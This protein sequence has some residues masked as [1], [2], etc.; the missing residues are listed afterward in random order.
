MNEIFGEENFV[1][2]IIWE[3]KFAPQNDARWFSENH[4][5]ILAI[6]KN[7]EEWR[8]NLLTRGEEALARYKNLDND[9]R[10]QW[11]SGDLLRKDVQKT[12]LYKIFSPSGKE[13]NP[14]SGTSWRVPESKF[15]ELLEE[16][17][18]WF[19]SDGNGV[20]RIKRFLSDVKDGITPETIFHYAEVGHTQEASQELKKVFDG[21]GLFESPKPVRLLKRLL[22][23]ATA[24]SEDNIILDFFAGSGTTAHAVLDLNK[25]DGGNRKFICVQIPEET[26]EG[27][28]ARKAG[29]VTIADITKARIRKVIEKISSEERQLLQGLTL[30]SNSQGQTL[31]APLAPL[32][33]KVFRTAASNFNIWRTR[34]F[35]SGEELQQALVDHIKEVKQATPENKLHEILIKAG[36][37]LNTRV[38]TKKDYFVVYQFSKESPSKAKETP[39][40]IEAELPL[41]TLIVCLS[42]HMDK[43][44]VDAIIAE[45]PKQ[46]IS[47]DSAFDGKDELKVNMYLALRDKKIEFSVV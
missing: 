10:G 1:A 30:N 25:E 44:I 37:D 27:S 14:P 23:I 21:V 45:N 11:M 47:L 17:R 9:P 13:N 28:E 41:K 5:Y 15:K 26:P 18:I 46:V 4:D 35:A 36:Y 32:G 16:N 20:P 8:P 6:A 42:E 29:Y 7:K 12:G 19:G 38:E 3:K 2:S 39:L 22:Q 40:K 31:A 24:T 34:E 33:F 43:S